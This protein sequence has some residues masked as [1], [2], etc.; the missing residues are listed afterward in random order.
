MDEKFKFAVLNGNTLKLIALIAM[1]VDH[2][3][4]ILFPH[5][6]ILRIIG[7]LAYP[8]FAFMI[9]EGCFY[10]KHKYRY[11]F[12]VLGIG[13][14]CQIVY[15]VMFGS[16]YMNIMIVFAF[17]ILITFTIQKAIDT[18]KVGMVILA[19][20]LVGL[21]FFLS[22]ILPNYVKGLQFDYG[23]VGIILPVAVYLIPK[24]K[25]KLAV[26]AAG[27]IVLS[28]FNNPSVQYWGLF[29]IPLLMLYNGKR[30]KLKIKHFF[31][32]YYPAHMVGIW[33]V[34]FCL[35]H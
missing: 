17:S 16:L 13:A 11:F 25:L 10:T 4:E 27:L 33:L 30:G 2:V 31:Y 9:A 8:I 23:F 32:I 26:F 24:F 28:V 12:E 34:S 20:F 3:G 6:I 21:A 22:V 5:I 19:A 18:R 7:R 35:M 1:T 29:S 14:L 15:F